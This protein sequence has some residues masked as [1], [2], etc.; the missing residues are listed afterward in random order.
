MTS[1]VLGCLALT[2]CSE[3]SPYLRDLKP[4]YNQDGTL[5]PETYRI[6][7]AWMQHMLKDLDVCYKDAD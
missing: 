5:D 2:G 7:K 1:C 3:T 4:S 6:S